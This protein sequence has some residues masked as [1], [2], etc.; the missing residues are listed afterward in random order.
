MCLHVSEENATQ[1]FAAATTAHRRFA[2]KRSLIRRKENVNMGFGVAADVGPLT[3]VVAIESERAIEW[4][5]SAWK[6][7]GRDRFEMEMNGW[8]LRVRIRVWCRRR[9]V[10]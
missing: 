6:L 7:D 3:E 10:V 9:L 8:R 2:T 1:S 5:T 4:K